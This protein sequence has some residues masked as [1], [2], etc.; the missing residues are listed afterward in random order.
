MRKRILS[1]LL[2]LCMVL[3]MLPLP[4]YANDAMGVDPV[5]RLYSATSN[6]QKHKQLWQKYGRIGARE[7]RRYREKACT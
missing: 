5:T 4:A 2:V 6:C 3:G 7:M 1:T